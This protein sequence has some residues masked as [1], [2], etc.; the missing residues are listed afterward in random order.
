MPRADSF[1][2]TNQRETDHENEDSWVRRR[3]HR[4]AATRTR[5]RSG[6]ARPPRD[7]GRDDRRQRPTVRRLEKTSLPVAFVDDEGVHWHSL[8]ALQASEA[9]LVENAPPRASV[10]P[11]Y[12]ITGASVE[13][14][15]TEIHG[16]VRAVHEPKHRA[17]AG[18]ASARRP[19]PRRAPQR[20]HRLAAA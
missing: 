8:S 17:L 13:G 10:G 14:S 1:P 20:D 4:P 2:L 7:G 11:D 5:R 6:H 12:T 15:D 16:P 19:G 3:W 9:R 18:R